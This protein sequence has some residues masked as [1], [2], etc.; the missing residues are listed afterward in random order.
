MRTAGGAVVCLL[1][2]SV[3]QARNQQTVKDCFRQKNLLL[4]LSD[5]CC[6][7]QAQRGRRCCCPVGRQWV[8]PSGTGGAKIQNIFSSAG[9]RLNSRLG[10]S[11]PSTIG[12]IFVCLAD[13]RVTVKRAIAVVSTCWFAICGAQVPP[14]KATPTRAKVNH[15]S[16][17]TALTDMHIPSTRNSFSCA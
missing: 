6:H 7:Q 12:W 13:V 10:I 1:A 17:S 2:E 5:D 9:R 3:C 16:Q 8:T 15:F 4:P 11:S 14:P